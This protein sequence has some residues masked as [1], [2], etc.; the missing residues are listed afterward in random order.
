MNPSRKD[1]SLQLNNALWAYMTTFKTLIRMSPYRLVYGKTCHLPVEL[2][3]RAYWAIKQL[4]FNFL[5]ADSQRKLQLTELEELRN[6]AYDSLRKYKEHMKKV[7][8]QSILRRS[9][10]P[11]QKVILY[12]SRLHLF[13]GKLKSRWTG[14]FIIRIVFSHGAIKIED[15]KNGNTFKVNGQRV[16]PF[17]ELRS[18]EVEATLLEDPIY[19]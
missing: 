8:D 5:K 6:D 17:L 16:K 14:P 7:H 15:P 10:E 3:H 11:G 12:N 1:W 4:N 19:M 13:P 18:L 2:E 9:F